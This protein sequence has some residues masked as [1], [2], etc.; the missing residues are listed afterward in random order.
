MIEQQRRREFETK[1]DVEALAEH[2]RALESVGMFERALAVWRDVL[3]R[4]GNSLPAWEALS[5][6]RAA[7]SQ[8]EWEDIPS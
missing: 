2:A 8:Q 4:D 7:L 6:L 3:Q 5:R 1:T